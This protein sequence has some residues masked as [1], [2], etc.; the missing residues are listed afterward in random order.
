MI[1]FRRKFRKFRRK[2]TVA[3]A[4]AIRMTMNQNDMMM[5]ILIL[6]FQV[7]ME[8]SSGNGATREKLTSGELLIF[9]LAVT[10]LSEIYPAT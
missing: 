5:I 7:I 8:C 6:Q 1:Q 4:K 2:S 9:V 3:R 10:L